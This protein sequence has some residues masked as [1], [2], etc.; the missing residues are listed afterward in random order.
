VA[1]DGIDSVVVDFTKYK[2]LSITDFVGTFNAVET[3]SGVVRNT[4]VVLTQDNATTIRVNAQA[5]IPGFHPSVF[6][7]WGEAFVDGYGLNGDILMNMNFETNTI[8]FT[9][10]EYWGRSDYDYD[11]WYTGN[12]TFDPCSMTTNITFR[13]HWDDANFD[14]AGNAV[15]TVVI[16]LNSKK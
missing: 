7:G 14:D 13:L 4:T 9:K 5:G 3:R 15:C 11:Y 6:I 8:G 16:D 12:G 1:Y 10:G 2:A